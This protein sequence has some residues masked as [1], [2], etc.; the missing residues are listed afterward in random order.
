MSLGTAI[1][2][3][4]EE[5]N[6]TQIDLAALLGWSQARVSRVE[7]DKVEPDLQA[8]RELGKALDVAPAD[9]A[10]HAFSEAA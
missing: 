10:G 3:R 4:R 9:L 7:L 1:R 2:S 6:L 5:R 8:L